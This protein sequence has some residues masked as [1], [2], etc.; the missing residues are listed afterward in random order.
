MYLG[1]TSPSAG[2]SVYGF[3]GGAYYQMALEHQEI[4]PGGFQTIQGAH[5]RTTIG[6]T[7]SGAAYVPDKSVK[8][9]FKATVVVGTAPSPKPFNG[10][11]TFEMAFNKRMGLKYIRFRGRRI[12]SHRLGRAR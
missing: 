6:A 2:F 1:K 4:A 11:A 5:D 3:G 10:D 8:L 9:G 12:L 7:R